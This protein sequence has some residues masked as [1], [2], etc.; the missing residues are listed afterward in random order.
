MEK[1]AILN[2]YPRYAI[3]SKGRIR[4]L[5]TGI[6]LKQKDGRGGYYQV[7]LS[8]KFGKKTEFVHRLVAKAFI[9]NNDNKP[10]VNH[11]DGNKKNNNVDNL[12]WVTAKENKQHALKNNLI[13]KF[14]H[15]KEVIQM[16][17]KGNEIARFKSACEASRVVG[18]SQGNIS[19]VCRGYISVDEF[20]YKNHHVTAGG[21][22]W[23]YV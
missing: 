18:V 15:Q 14:G 6:L 19:N 12:E 7:E 21:Y 2:E 1:W 10:Q 16:D 20:G 4:S 22:K 23:K 5:I 9:K 8:S 13:K 17:M 11:I 3:S